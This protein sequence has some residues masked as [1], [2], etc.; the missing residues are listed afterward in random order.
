MK[1][2]FLTLVCLL[3][4]C[5]SFAQNTEQAVVERH[6]KFKGIPIDG[7]P[8]E[9][10]SKLKENGFAYKET[11]ISGASVYNGSFA[12]YNNCDVIVKSTN[13]LVYEV[14]VIFPKDYTWNQLNN[15]YSSL[16]EMLTT[17]YGN[18]EGEETFKNTPSYVNINDDNDKYREVGYGRCVYYSSFTS[19]VDGVGIIWLE[20][21]KSC[22]V[23]LHYIDY[24][25]ERKKES[26]AIN[27]L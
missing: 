25:N 14:V 2:L 22:S 17:K 27:D 3:A 15:T 23:G 7:T 9:F 26:A 13:N 16:K 5:S 21:K 19:L 18:P 10:S 8:S 11:Y 6:L 4:I 24:Y 1:K 12:G 20:I